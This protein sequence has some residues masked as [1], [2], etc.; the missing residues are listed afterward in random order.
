MKTN[1]FLLVWATALC[2]GMAHGATVDYDCHVV[3]ENN[4]SSIVLV[5]AADRTKAANIAGRVQFKIGRGRPM[6]VRQVKECVERKTE[7]FSD[8]VM[9]LRRST[10]ER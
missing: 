9:E 4:T 6:V 1:W 10:M 7:R 2:S 3:L 5:E 8:P